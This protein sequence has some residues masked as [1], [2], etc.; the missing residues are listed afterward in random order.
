MR[1][2]PRKN[3]LYNWVEMHDSCNFS[4]FA[5]MAAIYTHAC[6]TIFLSHNEL[7]CWNVRLNVVE[8]TCE[9]RANYKVYTMIIFC[10]TVVMPIFITK[11]WSSMYVSSCEHTQRGHVWSFGG[12]A[13]WINLSLELFPWQNSGQQL[14][15]R[16]CQEIGRT[17][18]SMDR[19][20]PLPYEEEDFGN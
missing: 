1:D 2:F 18:I 7:V 5:I 14:P 16:L 17:E 19:N 20:Y 10:T 15:D 13:S 6:Q 8:R 9:M 4:Q 11:I 12:E 3:Y